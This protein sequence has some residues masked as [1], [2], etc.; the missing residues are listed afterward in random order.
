MLEL[1]RPRPASVSGR[2]Y[3]LSG[4]A[5]TLQYMQYRVSVVKV[6]VRLKCW[7]VRLAKLNKNTENAKIF[8]KGASSFN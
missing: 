8:S 4:R 5:E 2:K 3:G 1:V 6:K 7:L